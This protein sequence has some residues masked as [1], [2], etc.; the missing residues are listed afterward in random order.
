MERRIMNKLLNDFINEIQTL[1][2]NSLDEKAHPFSSYAPFIKYNNKFYVYLSLMAKHSSNLIINN[3]C[4]I[5]IIEDECKCENIFA[6]KRVNF[7]CFSKRLKQNTTKEK[8]ILEQFKIKFD[9]KM[10][11][12][13]KNMGDFYLFEFTLISGQAVFGFGKAF[14][15][16]GENLDELS[17]R[18]NTT[19]HGKK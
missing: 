11:D 6:R 13:L 18:D 10:I 2:I 1:C 4:S 15:I 14:D 7:Q 17:Q 8:E 19:G 16:T 12:M 3:K 9:G 5:L